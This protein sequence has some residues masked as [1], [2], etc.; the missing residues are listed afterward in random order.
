MLLNGSVDLDIEV[1]PESAESVVFTLRYDTLRYI[2]L[3]YS[4]AAK[5]VVI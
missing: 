2:T 4:I 5:T 1:T 3:R